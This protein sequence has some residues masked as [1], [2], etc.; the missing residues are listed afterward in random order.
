MNEITRKA[1]KYDLEQPLLQNSVVVHGLCFWMEDKNICMLPK[2]STTVHIWMPGETGYDGLLRLF[3]KKEEKKK[4]HVPYKYIITPLTTDDEEYSDEPLTDK[5][6]QEIQDFLNNP[7][8]CIHKMY[9]R[10]PDHLAPQD[11]LAW[12]NIEWHL[13]EGFR[14]FRSDPTMKRKLLLIETIEIMRPHF[15]TMADYWGHMIE[16]VDVPNE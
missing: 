2:D 10:F 3:E 15:A 7:V 8:S 11:W 13:I 5:E 4:T 9:E 1:T 16:L 12:Y 14:V 6:E